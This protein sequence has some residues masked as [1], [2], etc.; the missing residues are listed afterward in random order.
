MVTTALDEWLVQVPRSDGRKQLIQGLTVPQVT[1]EFPMINLQSAVQ[2]VKADDVNNQDL[3]NCRLPQEAGGVVDMLL[4]IKYSSIFPVPVHS[5]PCGLT[6]YRS[7][8]A[9][10]GGSYD[11]CIGGPHRS[12]KVLTGMAGG[13]AQLLS[14][15]IDGL[16]VYREWG[17]P[18]ITSICMTSQEEMQAVN[19]NKEEGDMMEFTEL[20]Y[21]EQSECDE[22]GDSQYSDKDQLSDIED[23]EC[24][25]TKYS[26]CSHCLF[27]PAPRTQVSSDE[28]IKDLKRFYELHESGLEVD[29]RCPDC[30][31]CEKC[32]SSDKTEKISLREECEQ[33]EINKSV[34]LDLDNKR[35]QC[36]L[37][38]IG[39]E[40][41]FLTCNRDRAIKILM[42]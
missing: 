11:C 21:L 24:A 40:R 35:I 30:R 25:I 15:F 7:Q 32:K 8:L 29:Y 10:H 38:L 13:A 17:P 4:G 9:S 12:F 5:L 36:T 27:G 2:D 16:R 37:P 23:E 3:Q 26:C 39:K 19:M 33:F 14:H 28:R 42:Q 34:K 22:E 20:E 41:D 1:C 18:R 31:D 6:I